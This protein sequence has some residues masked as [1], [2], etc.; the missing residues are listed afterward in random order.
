MLA[1]R[2]LGSSVPAFRTTPM[3]AAQPLAASADFQN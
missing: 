1:S 2:A 3:R